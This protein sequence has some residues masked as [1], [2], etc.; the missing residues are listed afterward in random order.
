MVTV[1]GVR[2]P[3]S[4]LHPSLLVGV[5]I[6]RNEGTGQLP[7]GSDATRSPIHFPKDFKPVPGVG[8]VMVRRHHSPKFILAKGSGDTHCDSGGFAKEGS[9]FF[10]L[11]FGD[12]AHIAGVWAQ[13][14]AVIVTLA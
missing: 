6:I 10:C 14:G 12:G 9:L 3:L 4:I 13:P 1:E 11:S 7:L 8:E 5:S 2:Y